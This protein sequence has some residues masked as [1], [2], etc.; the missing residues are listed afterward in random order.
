MKKLLAIFILFSLVQTSEAQSRYYLGTSTTS[1]LPLAF[2]ASWEVPGGAAK[3]YAYDFKDGSSIATFTSNNTGAAAVR[4]LLIR[5]FITVPLAA[6]TLNTGVVIT[7]QVRGNMSSTTSRT[8]RG[9]LVIKVKNEDGTDNAT[10]AT[11]FTTAYTTTLT[12]RTYTFTLASPVTIPAGGRLCFEFGWEYSTGTNTATNGS[13]SYGSS[14]ATDLSAD[15]TSTTANNPF[16]NIS[17][18]VPKQKIGIM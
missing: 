11:I 6:Q 18:T 17:V 8:G 5:T 4:D 3:L 16:V 9:R 14:S 12:N 7:A 10:I 1:L 15:N 2:D 13:N